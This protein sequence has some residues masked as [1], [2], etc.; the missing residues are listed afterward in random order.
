MNKPHSLRLQRDPAATPRDSRLEASPCLLDRLS[1]EHSP[2]A[3]GADSGFAS[4]RARL[5]E[6]LL[7]D[8]NWLLNST[9]LEATDDLAAYPHVRRSVVNFGLG[10]LAGARVSALDWVSLESAIREA[11]V[12]FEPR[13]L[14]E[15]VEVRCIAGSSAEPQRS[16]LSLEIHGQLCSSLAPQTLLLRSEI[17]LESG[18]IA[19]RSQGNG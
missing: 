6:S 10:A 17:D 11:I 2:T 19:L 13:I 4:P 14:A 9:N 18:H 7:R 12:Q 16:T 1:G 3:A 5:R 8:L 15:S